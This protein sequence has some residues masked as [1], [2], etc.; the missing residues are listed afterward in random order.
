MV[1]AIGSREATLAR[2]SAINGQ[3]DLAQSGLSAFSGGQQGMSSM[4]MPPMSMPAWSM[5][6]I[7][8]CEPRA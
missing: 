4:F 5:A 6:G 8:S 7:G 1:I 3:P 2:Q